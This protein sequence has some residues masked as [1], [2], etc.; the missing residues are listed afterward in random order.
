MQWLLS[1]SH[2]HGIQGQASNS[3]LVPVPSTPGASNWSFPIIAPV[4][5]VV[6]VRSFFSRHLALEIPGSPDEG[7]YDAT[8][9]SGTRLVLLFRFMSPSP[10]LFAELYTPPFFFPTIALA[11]AEI[12]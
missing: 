3:K 12:C 6:P 8:N 9:T 2:S 4:P 7:I 5:L 1:A 11:Q 10:A